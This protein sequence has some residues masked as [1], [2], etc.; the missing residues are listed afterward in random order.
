MFPPPADLAALTEPKPVPR[1]EIASDPVA[2]AH[3]N[4]A[5]ES[6]GERLLAAGG[7][8]CRFYQRLRMPRLGPCPA[9]R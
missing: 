4:A 5:L 2:E 9:A 6:W 7:R 8:L 1:D 3:Y